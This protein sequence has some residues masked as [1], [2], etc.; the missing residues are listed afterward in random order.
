MVVA[1]FGSSILISKSSKKRGGGNIQILMLWYQD[2]LLHDDSLCPI[3]SQ[4][5][6]VGHPVFKK[7]QKMIKFKIIFSLK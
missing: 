2:F 3:Y 5:I 4:G 1:I 7:L 6:S